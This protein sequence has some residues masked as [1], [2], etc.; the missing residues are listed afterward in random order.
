[1]YGGESPH[2][3]G[4]KNTQDV[5]LPFLREIGRV[6]KKRKGYVQG[7]SPPVD[8]CRPLVAA[9]LQSLH[10]VLPRSVQRMQMNL[11][12]DSQG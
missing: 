1:M 9:S 2:L 4:V 10:L 5:Q 3:N 6:S 11:P 12:H 7:Y 8:R